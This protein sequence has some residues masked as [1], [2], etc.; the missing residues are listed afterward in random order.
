MAFQFS[1]KRLLSPPP[2]KSS[3]DEERA[4]KE[5]RFSVKN[6]LKSSNPL[7]SAEI[8]HE[9]LAAQTCSSPLTCL[10]VDDGPARSGGLGVRVA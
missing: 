4:K 1:A 5:L 6:L 8:L 10:A 9:L 3:E 2:W 7:K